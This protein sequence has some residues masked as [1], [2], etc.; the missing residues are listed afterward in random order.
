ML[1]AAQSQAADRQTGSTM[2]VSVLVGGQLGL[3]ASA[4]P[5]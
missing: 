5:A 4:W 2:L 1:R 3:W